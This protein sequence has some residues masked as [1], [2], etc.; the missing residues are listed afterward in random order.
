MKKLLFIALFISSSLMFAQKN[1][2]G[3]QF[4]ANFD[5]TSAKTLGAQEY[6]LTASGEAGPYGRVNITMHFTNKLNNTNGIGEF[7]GFAWSQTPEGITEATLQGVTRSEGD[8]FI[9]YSYD[10]LTNG[11]IMQ[12]RGE[13]DFIANKIKLEVKE[14]L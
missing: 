12:W 2:M 8:K 6:E 5:I 9:G 14:V 13:F 3:Q 10:A 11:K 4:Q 1:E 7:T